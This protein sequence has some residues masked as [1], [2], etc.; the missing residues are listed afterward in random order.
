MIGRNSLKMKKKNTE[1]R[2][3]KMKAY[4]QEW[5]PKGV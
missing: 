3:M 5:T 2:R 1:S 4:K